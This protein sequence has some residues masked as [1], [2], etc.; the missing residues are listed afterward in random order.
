[1]P[2]PGNPFHLRQ[3]LADRDRLLT[4][5][6]VLLD[7]IGTGVPFKDLAPV[8]RRTAALIRHQLNPDLGKAARRV[9]R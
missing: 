6:A 5:V 7:A 4:T 9:A 2:A 1:M 8:C 3:Q